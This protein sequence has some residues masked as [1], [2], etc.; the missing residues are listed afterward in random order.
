M[1]V[2]KFQNVELDWAEAQLKNW[3][4]YVDQNQFDQLE[5][6]TKLRATRNGGTVLEVIATIES[7]QKNIRDTMKDYLALFEIV[8]RLRKDSEK[9]EEVARG[10]ETI[11]LRLRG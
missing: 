11:P 2:N 4:A 9:N 8:K 7:Q 1:A 5:D 10:G 6:R 3:Q